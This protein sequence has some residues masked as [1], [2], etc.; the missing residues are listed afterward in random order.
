MRIPRLTALALAP[1]L[2]CAPADIGGDDDEAVDLGPPP[3]AGPPV[4][5]AACGV[6]PAE[7]RFLV[8]TT[9]DF[10]TGAVSALDL[11]SGE[12]SADIA[13]GSTD[14]R[15]FAHRGLV[16]LLH[17]YMLDALDVIDPAAS[18]QTVHQLAI[19]ADEL[20]SA[21][22]QTL[23]FADDDLA[24]ITLLA[25][26]ELPILDLTDPRA[27]A[28]AGALQLRR[29]ADDDGSPEPGLAVVCG[30]TLFVALQ[31]LD[32]GDGFRPLHDH[33]LVVALDRASGRL[34]DLDPDAAGVQ[35]I[36]LRGLW[37]RQWRRDP[38][39]PSGRTLLVLTTGLE[40]LDLATGESAWLV[41]PEVLTTIG[42][43]SYLQPQAFA[44]DRQ[45]RAYIASYTADFAEVRVHRF[46]PGA[47]PPLVPQA[48]L[49]GVQT[50]EQALEIVGDTLWIG[51]R[52]LGASGLRAYDLTHN[53]PLP[54]VGPLST[55]L[56]PYAIA[57]LP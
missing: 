19:S 52:S 24:Y 56:A 26:S 51:D 42:V 14:A 23:A 16:Y 27:P 9:T 4:V 35:G 57:P 50:A 36:E 38:A 18:W 33:D 40:R 37:A 43:T 2:S 48:I 46:D 53:P 21:N 7:P 6:E 12:V 20:A 54:L 17:R 32:R 55:G 44:L 45:G 1:A 5:S 41:P 22:P 3:I 39:D 13:L 34:H 11:A 28:R 8:V 15:P 29:L 10:S 47:P 25:S 31:R 49:G 30:G